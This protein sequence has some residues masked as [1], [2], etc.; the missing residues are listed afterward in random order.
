MS[1]IFKVKTSNTSTAV[2]HSELTD[3][4]D[5]GM[6][7]EQY[8]T[9]EQLAEEFRMTKESVLQIL[10]QRCIRPIAKIANR[11]PPTDTNPTGSIKGGRPK[12]AFDPNIARLA[13]S[14]SIEE[15]FR[16]KSSNI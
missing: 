15:K 2:S 5:L 1:L 9:S 8:L 3:V 12:L 16:Q 13:I 11:N 7:K 10:D 4:L 14:E 6:K